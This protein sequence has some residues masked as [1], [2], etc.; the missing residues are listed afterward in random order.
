MPNHVSVA[1]PHTLH[2]V[3]RLRVSLATTFRPRAVNVVPSPRRPVSCRSA[4]RLLGNDAPPTPRQYSPAYISLRPER[5]S[6]RLLGNVTPPTPTPLS[7]YPTPHTAPLS[8]A[9]VYVSLVTSPC[10]CRASVALPHT[11]PRPASLRSTTPWQRCPAHALV[12]APPRLS[13]CP[14]LPAKVALSVFAPP[15]VSSSPSPCLTSPFVRSR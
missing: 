13:S 11:S 3:S 8:V 6:P 1:P 9:S 5:S 2:R 12:T 14:R 4:P 10:L 7:K 15:H